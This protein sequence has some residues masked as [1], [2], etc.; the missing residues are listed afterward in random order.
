MDKREIPEELVIRRNEVNRLA[1]D[2]Y[3]LIDIARYF[4][5]PTNCV[6]KSLD[7]ISNGKMTFKVNDTLSLEEKILRANHLLEQ[8]DTLL[9]GKT[10]IQAKKEGF[11]RLPIEY[12]NFRTESSKEVGLQ[13]EL[14]RIGI[15]P[16]EICNYL[17]YG[18]DVS[19]IVAS[20]SQDDSLFSHQTEVAKLLESQGFFIRE[21]M[22]FCGITVGKYMKRNTEYTTKEKRESSKRERFEKGDKA[23]L[24][25]ELYTAYQAGGV[26][27]QELAKRYGISRRTVITYLDKYCEYY[28]I[29]KREKVKSSGNKRK[30]GVSYRKELEKRVEDFLELDMEGTYQ[31]KKNWTIEKVA[32]ELSVTEVTVMKYKKLLNEKAIVMK[33]DQI[34][35]DN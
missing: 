16:K 12:Q 35:K 34:D 20:R 17:G 4:E 13:K 1:E 3:G 21:I 8:R 33:Q 30:N 26:T 2:G 5:V 31:F 7:A 27:Q 28:Q 10:E 6:Q 11:W 25:K 9:K 14:R 29:P 15:H 23:S 22:E 24:A 19:K 18:D 32:H